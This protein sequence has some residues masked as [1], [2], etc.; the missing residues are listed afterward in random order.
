[1]TEPVLEFLLNQAGESE[2]LGDAGIETFRDNPYASCG[3]ESGQNSADAAIAYPVRMAF[4][5]LDVAT[6]EIPGI[7]V[8]TD[9][10]ERCLADAKQE[11]DRDFFTQARSMLDRPITKVL[12]ISD[13]NTKGLAGPSGEEGTPFHSLL[14]GAGVSNNKTDTSGGS[15]GIGKNASF[16]ISDLQTVFYST[17]YHDAAE[18]LR[19]SAQGKCRMVSHVDSNGKKRRATGYWGNPDGYIAVENPAEVPEWMRRTEV[20]TSIFCIGFRQNEGWSWSI[21]YSLLINFFAAIHR[22]RM[23]FEINGGEIKLNHNTVAAMFDDQ[24]IIDAAEA[25][26]QKSQLDFSH[27]LFKCL[28]SPE[29]KDIEQKVQGLGNMR[30]RILVQDGLPKRVGIVRNGM[31]I[32]SELQQ[33]GDK[34]QRFVGTREFVA[35]V[36]PMADAAS[37]L[38]KSIE[39]PRHDSFSANRLSDPVKRS[40]AESAMRQ[41]IK[42]LRRLIEQT[43]AIEEEDE[44]TLDELARFFAENVS[45]SAPPDP[46]AENDPEKYVYKPARKTKTSTQRSQEN[47]GEEGGGGKKETKE[48]GGKRSG[49]QQGL[50]AGS[51]GSGTQGKAPPLKL[52]GLRTVIP[53][54]DAAALKRTVWFTPTVTGLAIVQLEATGMNNGE[55]L[56]V[57]ASS[58]GVIR[59]GKVEIDLREGERVSLQVTFDAP[60]AGPVEVFATAQIQE[61]AA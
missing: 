16:A 53:S 51:G 3:R 41:L 26:G 37:K 43:A 46:D 35:F 28:T 38:M 19:F 31:L 10:V 54:D 15:F 9:T 18:Q 4:D 13:F 44:V 50:G 8:L 45:G 27:D 29:A 58:V 59:K 56:P 1:M 12:R 57:V 25:D 7:V 61:T 39:N 36:E 22:D 6:S 14:K 33:F 23:A 42:D 60:Y 21:A 55:P 49:N 24:R 52:R 2:G 5:V 47:A 40:A 11:K 48:S 34:L 32:T 20:G 17:V 30:F